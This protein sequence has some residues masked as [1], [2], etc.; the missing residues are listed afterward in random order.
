MDQTSSLACVVAV[1]LV[2]CATHRKHALPTAASSFRCPVTIP[3]GSHAPGVVTDSTPTPTSHGNGK[4]WTVLPIDGKLQ[5]TPEKDGSTGAKFPWWK[6]VPSHLTVTGR[7][8]DAAAAPLRAWIPWGYAEKFQS[9]ALYFPTSG[10]WEISG[11]AGEAEL[12][13]VVEMTIRT[14]SPADSR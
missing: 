3:N 11:K 10:C 1:M 2:G 9:T 4:I 6:E 8:L 5:I 7:R 14:R 12:T 13:F